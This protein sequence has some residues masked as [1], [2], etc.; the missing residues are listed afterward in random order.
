VDETLLRFAEGD[1]ETLIVGDHLGPDAATQIGLSLICGASCVSSLQATT[2]ALKGGMSGS[3]L[4]AEGAG[5]WTGTLVGGEHRV[6]AG[7]GITDV[8]ALYW[9]SPY[10]GYWHGYYDYGEMALDLRRPNDSSGTAGLPVYVVTWRWSGNGVLRFKTRDYSISTACTGRYVDLKDAANNALGSLTYVHLD[11]GS[12]QPEYDTWTSNPNGWTIRYVGN[13]AG[14]QPNCW[15][16]A[17][18]LHQGQTTSSPSVF[19][20][21]QVPDS[22]GRINPTNPAPPSY[23]WMNRVTLTQLVDS[24]GD[25][26]SDSEEA[27]LSF[28]PQAWYDVYDVPVPAVADPTPNGPRNKVVD[29]GD[30]I[31]VLF[32]AFTEPTVAC[33]DNRNG[34]GVDYDCDKN[35][36]SVKDGL[37]YDRTAG[38]GPNPPWD[39]G[40][41]NG[42]VDMQDVLAAIGQAFWV[43]CSGPP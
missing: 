25:G 43:D 42:V 14:S 27:A 30:A 15:W 35:G 33:G 31:A 2:P 32:Y 22:Q 1:V 7:L 24:D 28:N 11:S 37:D 4:E 8:E 18:H 41:P 21:T 16:Q 20:N 40:P 29:M 3:A 10:D 12:M 17:P 38:S 26:C 19:H 39:A 9:G 23:N 6:I 34:N 13:V 36:D 5:L